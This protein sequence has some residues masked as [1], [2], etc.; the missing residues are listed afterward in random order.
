MMTPKKAVSKELKYPSK[1]VDSKAPM[2]SEREQLSSPLKTGIFAI[3][4]L[5]PIGLGQRELIIG[6][7]K[8]GKTS[9]ALST[10]INQKNR[11]IKV[12]YVSLGQKQTSITNV[13]Q[14]LKDHDALEYTMIISAQPELKL[15][16]YIAP[17]IAMAKAESI[18]AKNQDVLIVFDDLTKHANVYRE[19]S[20]ILERSGGREAYPADL[21]YLHSRLIE[22]GGKFTKSIG[23]GSITVLPIIETV[24]GDFATL[25]ATNVIS[26]TDGQIITDTQ[27]SKRNIFPAINVS[28]SVSRT[29]SAVQTKIIKS[30][31]RQLSKIHT[32]YVDAKKYEMIALDVSKDIK[33]IIGRGNILVKTF[34]QNG[35]LGMS[36]KKMFLYGK[37]IESDLLLGQNKGITKLFK[38]QMKDE[39]FIGIM[40]LFK[41]DFEYGSDM[42]SVYFKM[43]TGKPNKYNAKRVMGG[44]NE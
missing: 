16:Q 2:F 25:L 40:K 42:L 24:E 14:I 34:E 17:Y 39:T 6:D 41:D 8:T 11:D 37:I 9:I 31:S 38:E 36:S 5:I 35:Y 30:I 1:V 12:I 15:S 19:L 18:A 23:G 32:Q 29:G 13:Y 33:Q 44:G 43:L 7:R 26:I 22:R 28:L 3:D 10:I 27:L 20:L 21:F 4:T